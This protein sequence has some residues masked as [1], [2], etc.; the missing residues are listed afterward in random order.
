MDFM[1]ISHYSGEYGPDI[2]ITKG[3]DLNISGSDV[4]L[5]EDIVD[6]GMTLN[7]LIAHLQS[8]QP[9]SVEVCALLDKR[10][11]RIADVDVKYVGFDAPDE[12][13]VGYGLDYLESYRNLPFVGALKPVLT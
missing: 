10:A 6:T 7:W 8:R 12:F 4:V 9:A 5:I 1:S 2:R 11:R 13:L 3:L